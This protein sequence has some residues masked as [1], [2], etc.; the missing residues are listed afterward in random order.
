MSNIIKVLDAHIKLAEDQGLIIAYI[1]MP[2]ITAKNLTSEIESMIPSSISIELS[3][4][5]TYRNIPI[6]VVENS[7]IKV[8]Y[9][10]SDV[11]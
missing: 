9:A 5:K 8:C 10:I 6:R 3:T 1:S 2:R 4:I 7:S 11:F